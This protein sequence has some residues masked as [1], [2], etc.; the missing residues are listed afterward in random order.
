MRTM[1]YAEFLDF[2]KENKLKATTEDIL[3]KSADYKAQNPHLEDNW[4]KSY[5]TKPSIADII[6]GFSSLLH[7]AEHYMEK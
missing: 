7:G 5:M 1:S 6:K 2:L 4:F 3:D